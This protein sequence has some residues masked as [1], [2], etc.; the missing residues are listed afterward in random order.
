MR[1]RTEIEKEI[2]SQF[3]FLPP[4]FAPAKSA[5]QVL[6]SFWQQ[7]KLAYFNNPL[8]SLY[9]EKLFVYLSRN[10][11]VPYFLICHSCVLHSLGVKGKDIHELLL[12]PTPET[13]NELEEDFV[14]LGITNVSPASWAT[15]ESLEKSLLRC[16]ILLFHHPQK[17]RRCRAKLRQFLGSLMY[18]HLINFL[19]Y[20]RFCHQWLEN[21]PEISYEDDRRAQLYLGSL[22]LEEVKLAEFFDNYYS[23]KELSETSEMIE[24]GLSS[25]EKVDEYKQR[26][27][28]FLL[29]AP[30]PVMIHG[31]DGAIFHLNKT[32]TELTGYTLAETPTLNE[33]SRK[34][35]L[36]RQ[37]I[38]QTARLEDDIANP[39]IIPEQQNPLLKTTRSEL[40]MITRSGE[41]KVWEL[42]SAPLAQLADGKELSMAI[43][44]DLTNHFHA[45]TALWENQ[46]LLDLALETSTMGVWEWH[47]QDNRVNFSET[48]EILFGIEK[49][50]FRGKYSDFLQLIHPQ[51]QELVD[52][53]L[54]LAVK[55]NNTVEIA[56]RVALPHLTQN[57]VRNNDFRWR[58]LKTRGKVVSDAAGNPQRLVAVVVESKDLRSQSSLSQDESDDLRMGDLEKLLNCLPYHICVIQR[59]EMRISFCNEVFALSMGF[60]QPKQLQGQ[61]LSSC[62][63]VE[64]VESLSRQ[65][66]QVFTS[67]ETLNQQ[68]TIL[69]ADG[70]HHFDTLRIPL[71]SSSGDVY[72]LVSISRDITESVEMKEILS[73]KTME[74]ETVNQELESFSYSVSHDLYAPLRAIDGFSEVL[75][76]RYSANLQEKAKYY[77][78]RIRANSQR[79]GEAI[80]E[81][82]K[83]SQVARLP[84]QI[85]AVNLS[86]IATEIVTDLNT[87]DAERLAE[88]SIAPNAIVRGDPRL[89]RIVIDNLLS[90]AW[91]YAAKKDYTRIEFGIIT[92]NNGKLTYFVKDNGAGFDMNYADKLF[93]AFQRLHS[94]AEFSGTGI[95]L[96]IVKRIIQKHG[97]RIWAEAS[98]EMG[99]T[100]YFTLEVGWE[101]LLSS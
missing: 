68:E 30:F 24:E 18:N 25:L 3:G 93:V 36:D 27:F 51:E 85:T 89:L 61:T 14:H 44:L 84:L 7:T 60:D 16:A 34:T 2:E 8:P 82:L 92:Q 33:W 54:D 65:N 26:L 23:Q 64:L 11:S 69:L 97:G 50:S 63:N 12:K 75:L 17:A 56:Y 70:R 46:T 19:G 48:A 94:Q 67:G 100:F 66:L 58:W 45:E 62:L 49:G 21:N 37:T 55:N 9:K 73:V 42:Y 74:L 31:S 95:G 99:A 29:N 57:A 96:A 80:D 10:C 40:T 53:A 6:D 77:L 20:I 72:A 83:L 76:E 88:I 32:W 1:T 52:R 91:K 98:P 43:A 47:L 15:S 101:A 79:M 35:R 78:Q 71:K 38:A 86:A 87:R 39:I 5:P 41:E 22:I 28:N 4:L 59:E 81:L 90:N 13:E